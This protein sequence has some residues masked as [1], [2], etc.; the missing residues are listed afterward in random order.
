MKVAP[1]A[2]HLRGSIDDPAIGRPLVSRSWTFGLD[3]TG[4]AALRIGTASKSNGNPAVSFWL[5]GELGYS[6]AMKTD[7][8]YAPGE[9]EEDPRTFGEITLPSLRLGG[10]V[11]KLAFALSF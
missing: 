9:D 11:G 4:G 6:F 1:A 3:T 8:V 10:P 5:T 7:M 2:L